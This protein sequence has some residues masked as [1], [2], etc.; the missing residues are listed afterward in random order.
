MKNNLGVKGTAIE[1]FRSYLSGRR[2]SIVINNVSSKPSSLSHGVPQGSVLGPL[3]FCVYLIPLG[4]IIKKHNMALH[5]YAD[6]TQLYC[7]FDVKLPS[8]A[9]Q[10]SI[11]SE[12]V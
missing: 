1:W 4:E 5:I 7:F 3:L 6:D 10:P 8:A 11:C 2:Q 9:S 12:H